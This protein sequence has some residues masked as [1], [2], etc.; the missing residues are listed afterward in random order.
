M[1]VIRPAAPASC[2]HC[3]IEQRSHYQQWTDGPGWHKW[4]AP[5]Q[6]LI[7]A[8]MLARRAARTA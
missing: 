8:R 3:G 5:A 2:R 1:P 7:K 6:D 4:T